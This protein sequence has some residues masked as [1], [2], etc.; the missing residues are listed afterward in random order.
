MMKPL[1]LSGRVLIVGVST[2]AAAESAARAGF[3]AASPVITIDAFGDLDQD[4]RVRALSLPRDFGARFTAYAAA[5]AART[6]ACDAVVYLSN[7]ENRPRAVSRLAAGRALWGNPPEA[8]RRVRDPLI[9]AAALREHGCASPTACTDGAG[10]TSGRWLSKPLASGGGHRI[11]AWRRGTPVP[12]GRFLQELVD[13]TPGSVVFVAAA[14]RAVALGISSQLVGEHALGSG[15]Y[16][17]CGSIM[18]PAGDP[19]FANDEKLVSA[20]CGLASVVAEEFGLVGVNGIDF[21]ARD[22]IPYAVEVNPR[23]SASMELVERAFGVS[24]FAAHA[25]ACEA[26]ELPDFDLARARMGTRAF[27]K[28]VVFARRD[29]TIGDTRAWLA[30]ATVRDIPHPGERIPEG[31]PVCTVFAEGRDA[32]A[33]R[34]ALVHRADRVYAEL[35]RWEREVA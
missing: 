30:D 2:R 32:A 26:R 10:I 27:G 15:G 31:Q 18:M 28:A 21:V 22:G 17:Y 4:S 23:W 7:F 29:V 33:C 11:R 34:D 1:P 3:A 12:R 19:C 16:R 25:A 8:L 13:G 9:V 20:A 14:G 5:R 24:V 35:D 6:V